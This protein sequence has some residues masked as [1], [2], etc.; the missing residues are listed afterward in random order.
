[1]A[2]SKWHKK[3]R[4]EIL[5]QLPKGTAYSS[6]SDTSKLE[7]FNVPEGQ[8]L[9]KW[10]CLSEADIVVFEDKDRKKIAEVIEIESS[11]NPKKIIGIVIATHLCNICRINGK[12]YVLENIKLSIIYK[13]GPDKGKRVYNIE[14]IKSPLN[15][16]IKRIPGSISEFNFSPHE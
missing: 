2:E 13:M 16:F 8:E 7:L 11:F 10:H 1:M 6:H 14:I 15:E 5:G 4:E 3:V 12:N 9:K